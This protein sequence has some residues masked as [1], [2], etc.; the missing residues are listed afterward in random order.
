MTYVTSSA[1]MDTRD[2]YRMGRDAKRQGL[3][4]YPGDNPAYMAKRDAV[5]VPTA[6][7]H[8]WDRAYRDGW[9][10]AK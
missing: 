1:S 10:D 6:W 9:T 4:Q 8:A 3:P 7:V 5:D 2:A